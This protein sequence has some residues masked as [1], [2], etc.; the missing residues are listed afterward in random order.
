MELQE[1]RQKVKNIQETHPVKPNL[2]FREA[3]IHYRKII[4]N[5][6]KQLNNEDKELIIKE[7]KHLSNKMSS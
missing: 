2:S 5:W 6:Q 3:N 7:E 1:Y 4:E